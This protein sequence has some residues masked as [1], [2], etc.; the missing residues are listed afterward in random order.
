MIHDGIPRDRVLRRT[1]LVL[2]VESTNIDSADLKPKTGNSKHL[3]E[4]A[5]T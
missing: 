3:N 5:S 4:H 1:F 2:T